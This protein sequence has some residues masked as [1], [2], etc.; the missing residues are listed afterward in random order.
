MRA[1]EIPAHA[2]AFALLATTFF[3]PDPAARL[4]E[5]ALLWGIALGLGALPRRS[6]WLVRLSFSGVLEVVALWALLVARDVRTVEAYSL[7]V[8]AV[9]LLVGFLAMRRNPSITSWIGYGPALVAA[10]APSLIAIL[11]VAGDPVRRVALGVGG[12]VVVIGGALRRRQAP[13][14][15]GGAVVIIV[16]LHE[17]TQVWS[18]LPLWVPVGLGGAILVGIAITYE[19]R[20]R[21]LRSLRSRISAFT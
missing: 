14:V 15:I 3:L 11:P 1:L 5:V 18:R 9:A 19:R 16:A 10:F 7:P 17:V 13:V 4:S 6:G 21:D 20:L 12:L 2:G 8:A